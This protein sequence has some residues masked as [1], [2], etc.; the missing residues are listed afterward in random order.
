VLEGILGYDDDR[1]VQLAIAEALELPDERAGTRTRGDANAR[2]R[3]LTSTIS[4]RGTSQRQ[5]TSPRPRRVRASLFVLAVIE[6][7]LAGAH[8]GYGLPEQ[9]FGLVPPFVVALA[10]VPHDTL[11]DSGRYA[12]VVLAAWVVGGAG[13]LAYLL[14]GPHRPRARR[15]AAERVR[16]LRERAAAP[17]ALARASALAGPHAPARAGDDDRLA[18]SRRSRCRSTPSHTVSR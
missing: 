1:I 18:A 6:G 3:S 12:C 9:R 7:A 16:R 15:R 10:S 8:E 17:R 13:S 2:G 11:L 14:A 5:R 4:S